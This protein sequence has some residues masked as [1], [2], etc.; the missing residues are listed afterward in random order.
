MELIGLL[1]REHRLI[2]QIII[3]LEA[4]LRHISHQK[5]AHPSF[6]YKTVDFFRN[7]TDKIHHGKEEDILFLELSEKNLK[8]EH[9]RIMAELE[10][11]HRYERKIIDELVAATEKWTNG[12]HQ[13]LTNIYDK[14]KKLIDLYPRHIEKEDKHFFFPCQDYFSKKE[15]EDLLKVGY[16]YNQRFTNN[17]YED[18]MKYL[19]KHK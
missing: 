14:L 5:N 13:S 16:K 17:N 8:T 12:E 3:P 11:E 7:Y 4:E 6:I 18:Q 19:L 15:R 10:E 1:M 2:E 9:A